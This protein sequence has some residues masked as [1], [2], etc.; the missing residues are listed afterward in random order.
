MKI[1]FHNIRFPKKAFIMPLALTL[2]AL[3]LTVAGGITMI[4][5]KELFFSRLTRESATAYYAADT[6]LECATVIDESYN[7]TEGNGLFQYDL[8]NEAT[9]TLNYVNTVRQAQGIRTLLLTDIK[10]ASVSL[11]DSTQSNFTTTTTDRTGALLQD[12]NGNQTVISSFTMTMDT[13]EG[14]ITC[15][16][17]TVEKS[18]SWRQII[19]RGFNS[20]NFGT[21]NLLE[22]AVISTSER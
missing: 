11:F 6:A 7:G 13:G 8:I 22:R 3:I 10:C 1:I 21:K 4:I 5:G 2:S 19:A 12:P 14:T 16:K 20:C 9:S 17:V 18:I 15:A